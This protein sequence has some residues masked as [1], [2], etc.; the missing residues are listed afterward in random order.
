MRR[1]IYCISAL[2]LMTLPRLQE[3]RAQNSYLDRLEWLPGEVRIVADSAD[4]P[5]MVELSMAVK[6][7]S[8]P[9]VAPQHTVSIVPVLLTDTAG[10]FS[11]TPIYIDGRIRAKALERRM[12]LDRNSR[13]RADSSVVVRTG[14]NAPGTV[15]Y[16][17]RI[18]Y[19][20]AMLDGCVAL[21][22][23][24]HGCAECLVET[25][26]LVLAGV[27]PRFIPSWGPGFVQSPDGDSKRRERRYRAD[28]S[29][30][31]N[32]SQIAPGYKDNTAALEGIAESIHTAMNDSI[33]TVRA[34]RFMGYAS[35]EGPERF[36]TALSARR[37]ASLAD[38]IR[39]M[40]TS[41]PDSLFVVEGGAEDWD[42]FFAAVAGHAALAG[43]ETVA[44]VRALLTDSNRDSCE[45]ILRADRRLY[46]VLRTD[47]LPPLRR[48]EY[49]IEYDIRNF[50]PE[51]AER[52]WREHP[53]WL[54]INEFYSV[55]QLYGENDSRYVEVLLAAARTYPADVAAT[56]NAAMALHRAGMTTE[57][58]SLLSGRYEPGLLNTLGIIYAGEEMYPEARAA[59]SMA[60][61]SGYA[62]AQ[63]NLEQLDRV[64]EQ[65]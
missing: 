46:N 15:Y 60:A 62:D 24:A 64:E 63:T 12:V 34:V 57:A 22:E 55:A 59:F 56:H 52:L 8:K 18:P 35:P 2:I 5:K 47:I 41:L 31:V 61:A 58:V 6:W 36:N 51:E 37:A 1:L 65:L 11:F 38:H 33:Y 20:P 7:K 53:Q 42:G 25:D 9:E 54:S 28:L 16:L 17:S 39:S 3:L 50:T 32:L 27:L 4:G 13:Q 14:R 40:D 29:F 43:N 30:E 45:R 10:A 21:Y 48:T 49:V 26:T 19:L 23:T 44:R